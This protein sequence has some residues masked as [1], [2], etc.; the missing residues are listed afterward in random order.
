LI[1]ALVCVLAWTIPRGQAVSSGDFLVFWSVLVAG[2]VLLA[3]MSRRPDHLED[4][5]R[6]CAHDLS[7]QVGKVT[8]LLWGVAI[9]VLIASQAGLGGM[10]LNT[11]M[12]LLLFPV[13]LWVPVCLV[14]NFISIMMTPDLHD[15]PFL[16]FR[17]NSVA[18]IVA[19]LA[20]L[21]F[22]SR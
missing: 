16:A 15:L 21:V 8:I 22:E 13:G 3:R 4:H 11:G 5:N 17:L 10:S 7:A 14:A 2:Q 19:P 1:A 20:W 12:R 6:Q 9:L 18:A